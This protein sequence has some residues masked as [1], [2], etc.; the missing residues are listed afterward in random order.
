MARRS[1]GAADFPYDERLP[2][3]ELSGL[4]RLRTIPDRRL[5]DY[6]FELHALAERNEAAQPDQRAKPAPD[7]GSLR[8]AGERALL[9]EFG[10]DARELAAYLLLD[11]TGR[12]R[13]DQASLLAFGRALRDLR[14]SS[15]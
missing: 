1:G 3:R 9:G 6:L 7:P 10:P 15:R 5:A 14:R 8:Q 13:P 11:E 12:A 4:D 2:Q